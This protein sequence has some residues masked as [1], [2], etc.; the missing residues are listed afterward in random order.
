[1][2]TGETL[3][4]IAEFYGVSISALTQA[5][6]LTTASYLYPENELIIPIPT[7]GSDP[8]P[9]A[10]ARTREVVHTVQ[11]GETLSDIVQ[12]YGITIQKLLEANGMQSGATLSAGDTLVIP[13]DGDP[14]PTPT[15]GPTT[16][17]TPGLPFAAPH[18]LYPLQNADLQ[19]EAIVLHWTSVGI[20]AEDE[21]YALSLRYLG[22]RADGQ[23]S[24]IVAYTRITS[25]HI[26]EQWALGPEAQE[27]RFEWTV[28]VVRPADLGQPPTPISLAS[29][30]RR[31]RW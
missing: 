27:R 11:A 29:E 14:T 1:V 22:L 19:G 3:F 12:R 31:F 9:T 2:Q 16:T 4:S 25:W 30:I 17:P 10:T 23:P 15:P 21:W 24:E 5:N 7:T 28:Q 18:L 20:L 8:L 13:L 6:D 26:P